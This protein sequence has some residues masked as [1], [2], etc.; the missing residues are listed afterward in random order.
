[1]SSN[2]P[3][4]PDLRKHLFDT[5]AALRDKENPMEIDRARAVCQVAKEITDTA[6]VEIDYQRVTGNEI[7]SSFVAPASGA[8]RLENPS[9][10]TAH[11]TRQITAVPGGTVTTHRMR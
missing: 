7:N 9:S 2:S 6:R 1:M 4:L 3:T 11:G 5:L 10:V 8:P